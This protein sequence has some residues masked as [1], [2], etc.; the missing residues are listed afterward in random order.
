MQKFLDLFKDGLTSTVSS[1]KDWS[2]K[3]GRGGG[4]SVR[5]MAFY[6]SGPGLNRGG[7]PGS[8]LGFFVS[9]VGIFLIIKD[10]P[11]KVTSLFFPISY[12]QQCLCIIAFSI[13]TQM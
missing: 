5:A 7:A 4:A 10:I 2:E 8:N 12:H 13:V 1:T 6:P 11:I 9:V 3:R